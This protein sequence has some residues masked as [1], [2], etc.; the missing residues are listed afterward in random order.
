[1]SKIVSLLAIFLGSAIGGP[2]LYILLGFGAPVLTLGITP[3][4]ITAGTPSLPI[5]TLTL[6]RPYALRRGDPRVTVELL[7]EDGSTTSHQ[8]EVPSGRTELE[9][10]PGTQAEV[11]Q[12]RVH[13]GKSSLSAT[14]TVLPAGTT[15]LEIEPDNALSVIGDRQ[16]V[17]T[18]VWTIDAFGNTSA[19]REGEAMRFRVFG[20]CTATATHGVVV[21]GQVSLAVVPRENQARCQLTA[22]LDGLP[23][24]THD[25]NFSSPGDPVSRSSEAVAAETAPQPLPEL[26]GLPGTE[27]VAASGEGLVEVR[28]ALQGKRYGEA[29]SILRKHLTEQPADH[30]ARLLLGEVEYLRGELRSAHEQVSHFLTVNPDNP[31]GMYLMGEVLLKLDPGLTDNALAYFR[32]VIQHGKNSALVERCRQRIAQVEYRRDEG[33]TFETDF[34]VITHDKGHASTPEAN[35]FKRE[36][37]RVATEL[38]RAI[39]R[40]LGHTPSEK[41]RLVLYSREAY[42]RFNGIF[43]YNTAG[44]YDGEKIRLNDALEFGQQTQA[45]LAHEFTHAVL[46]DLHRGRPFPV[47]LEEGLAQRSEGLVGGERGTTPG[48]RATL[49]A[50][51]T[52]NQPS[53]DVLAKSFAHFGP[54]QATIAYLLSL[55]MVEYLERAFGAD[56]LLRLIRACAKGLPQDQA[57]NETYFKPF[58]SLVESFRASVLKG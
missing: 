42:Q 37:T 25:Y 56:R 21:G 27:L 11:V 12:L 23:P 48:Q 17:R 35:Q 19:D 32:A 30:R 5:L 46:A 40:E 22:E 47:W 57:A 38:Y 53:F 26:G 4:N 9:L 14:L 39:T 44:F 7:H 2:L 15:A 58:S 24:A 51:L 49:K 41:T 54:E 43:N 6:E 10:D 31:A 1:M 33:T 13:A 29:S 8:V 28:S 3:S 34:F 52:G 45:V 50:F 20:P 16:G 18:A 55:G 36:L